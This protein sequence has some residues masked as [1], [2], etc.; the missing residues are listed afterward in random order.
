MSYTEVSKVFTTCATAKRSCFAK[1]DAHFK[2]TNDN[3]EGKLQALRLQ[4]KEEKQKAADKL[5]EQKQKAVDKP[6]KKEKHQSVNYKKL[7]NGVAK[8][9]NEKKDAERKQ[10]SAQLL[11]SKLEKKSG[12]VKKAIQKQ[13]NVVE[14]IQLQLH[15][16]K[17]KQ[18][19]P[20]AKQL[21]EKQLSEKR[22]KE[23]ALHKEG[24][25]GM[26]LVKQQA[27]IVKAV[28]AQ[29]AQSESLEK[30]IRE[31][32]ERV[33]VTMTE[34]VDE[35]VK[36]VMH[37]QNGPAIPFS[38]TTL[39]GKVVKNNEADILDIQVVYARSSNTLP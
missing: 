31:S 9:R 5:K 20:G 16:V 6:E 24:Q 30:T 7:S 29:K 39:P 23:K 25:K 10:A 35:F 8:A 17:E 34:L 21:S 18:A 32:D 19:T 28:S 22:D 1:S 38:E 26:A 4:I 12:E 15:T 13:Q 33:H 14:K 2:S 11:I 37:L 27:S 3:T 36:T